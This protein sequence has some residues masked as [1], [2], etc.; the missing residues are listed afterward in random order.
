M[1]LQSSQ[2]LPETAFYSF[3]TK[4]SKGFFKFYILHLGTHPELP[5]RTPYSRRQRALR[6]RIQF[7]IQNSML[8]AEDKEIS[9]Y[10]QSSEK[11]FYMQKAKRSLSTFHSSHKTFQRHSRHFQPQDLPS[12][13]QYIPV[14]HDIQCSPGNTSHSSTSRVSTPLQHSPIRMHI[15]HILHFDWFPQETPLSTS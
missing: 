5:Y 13:F 15:L 10:I 9:E 1:A 2:R 4:K 7:Y 8:H 6:S 12:T 14:I 11:T 3:Y